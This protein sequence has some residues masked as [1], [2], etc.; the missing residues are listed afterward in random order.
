MSYLDRSILDEMGFYKLGRNVKISSNAT[1]YNVDEIELGDNVRIDDFS[2]VSGKVVFGRNIHVTPQCLIAGGSG[3]LVI[4]DFSTFAYG[5]K[6]F[7]QSDDYLGE[8]M[9]NSTVPS[10]YKNESKLKNV[11][12]KHSI[13]GAGAII[14]PGVNIGEGG[15]IGAGSV[16]LED[17]SPWSVYAGVPAR[18]L[19]DRKKSLLLLEKSYLESESS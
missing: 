1:I 13:I 6:V 18:K 2:V 4:H 3:G 7:T 10:V 11:V 14:M 5:V 17:T 15:A 12:G 9:T 8:T 19:K 16:V